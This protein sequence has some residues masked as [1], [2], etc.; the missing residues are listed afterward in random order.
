M[1]NFWGASAKSEPAEGSPKGSLNSHPNAYCWY[2]ERPCADI[3]I[4]ARLQ[5]DAITE[6]RSVNSSNVGVQMVFNTAS[7]EHGKKEHFP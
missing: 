4:S 5:S 2:L 6:V 3:H 1:S 7:S